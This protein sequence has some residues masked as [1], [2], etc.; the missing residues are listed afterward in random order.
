MLTSLPEE[1]KFYCEKELGNLVSFRSVRGGCI[2]NGGRLETAQGRVFIKWN[3]AKR[4]EGMF[5][6]EAKGLELLTKANCIRIPKILYCYEGEEYSCLI[7]EWIDSGPKKHD[8]WSILGQQLAALHRQTWDTYGLD[9]DNFIGSLTQHNKQKV[10]WID[11]FISQRLEPQLKLAAESGKMGKNDIKVFELLYKKLP[12]FL[13][14]EPPSL[15][16]GDLWS[17]NLMTDAL[18]MPTL[19][20]PAAAYTHREIDLGYTIL[21]G[22]FDPQFYANYHESFPLAAG[23]QERLD[24]YNLYPLLVH[25]NLFGGGYRQQVISILDRFM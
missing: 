16:H 17:G 15:T 8:Y 21:F 4:F 9:H 24:V 22:G 7:L 11:F 13:S 19:I 18:G 3:S 6:A 1:I 23:Y 14:I 2:N 12:F 20:D 25:V 10:D 5:T